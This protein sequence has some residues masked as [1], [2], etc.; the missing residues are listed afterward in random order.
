MI[1]VPGILEGRL[2]P[3][4]RL[5]AQRLLIPLL[6]LSVLP[7]AVALDWDMELAEEAAAMLVGERYF[8]AGIL[9]DG[10]LSPIE[11][12]RIDLSRRPF[13]IVLVTHEPTGVLLNLS[14]ESHLYYGIRAGMGLDQILEEP[15]MFMGM[16]EGLFNEEQTLYLTGTMAHYL[17]F[18]DHETHRFSFVQMLP[19]AIIGVR[20]VR[21]LWDMED[22]GETWPVESFGGP[23]YISLIHSVYESGQRTELQRATAELVFH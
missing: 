16:A 2:R 22:T 13:S 23:L 6:L 9:Q 18:S 8:A 14:H 17:F 15:E 1:C 7:Q 12:D 4:R 5:A 19:G 10:R 3:I 21:Y 20:E 11:D